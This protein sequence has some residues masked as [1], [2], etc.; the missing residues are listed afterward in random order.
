MEDVELHRTARSAGL[1]AQLQALRT[2]LYRKYVQEVASLEEQ[3]SSEL[4]RLREER[5]HDRRR[6]GLREERGE[7][8]QNL[9]CINGAGSSTEKLGAARQEF[10]VEEKQH[11]ERVEEEVAKVQYVVIYSIVSFHIYCKCKLWL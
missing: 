10:L 5:E 11:W 2:A 6:A 8:E 9:N 3:H 4:R 7:N 1:T